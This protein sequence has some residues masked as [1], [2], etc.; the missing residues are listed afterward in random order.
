MRFFNGY[1]YLLAVMTIK[2]IVIQY[3]KTVLGFLW[4]FV[5]PVVQTLV[6]YLIFSQ[7][8]RTENYFLYLFSGVLAWT[9]FS[10]AVSNATQSFVK[11]RSLIYKANFPKEVV[12]IAVVL[13]KCFNLILNLFVISVILLILG[14]LKNVNV[15]VL[16][17]GLLWLLF[18]SVGAVLSLSVLNAKYRDIGYLVQ[19][20]LM[21]LFYL[22][23]VIY[24]TSELPFYI[25]NFVFLNPLDGIF[26]LFHISFVRNM[27]IDKNA[28]LINIV[29]TVVIFVIGIYI[30]NKNKRNI[31]DWV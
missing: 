3:K 2:E 29:A 22:T 28:L 26:E 21:L 16:I 1:L 23:P 31:I 14:Y 12:P 25:R 9:F 17:V 30:F 4:I 7:I 18:L 5:N 11:E 20:V 19:P 15:C 13:S 24:K 6:I 10:Q 27:Y 8:I